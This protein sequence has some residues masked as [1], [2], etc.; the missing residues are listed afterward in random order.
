MMHQKS[1]IASYIKRFL[2]LI[3]GLILVVLGSFLTIQANIGLA[4]WE[5]FSIGVSYVTNIKI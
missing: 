3:F 4:P 2:K 5:T 1:A